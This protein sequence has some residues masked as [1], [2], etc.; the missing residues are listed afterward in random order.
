[1]SLTSNSF[2]EN[3]NKYIRR[4]KLSQADVGYLSGHFNGFFCYVILKRRKFLPFHSSSIWCP[5]ISDKN[6]LNHESKRH[7]LA[8]LYIILL[9]K[10]YMYFCTSEIHRQKQANTYSVAEEGVSK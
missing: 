7:V 3:I 2:T 5:L 4:I 10:H 6:L 9:C 1:M 8:N